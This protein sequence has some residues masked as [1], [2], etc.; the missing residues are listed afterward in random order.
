VRK[1][2]QCLTAELY[3]ESSIGVE[4]RN[5]LMQFYRKLEHGRERAIADRERGFNRVLGL[6]GK[7]KPYLLSHCRAFS[8]NRAHRV[9]GYAGNCLQQPYYT[10]ITVRT[11]VRL[12]G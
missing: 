2:K 6:L 3:I 10:S 8:P 9:A 5:N 4:N 1:Q 7:A 12:L 11:R